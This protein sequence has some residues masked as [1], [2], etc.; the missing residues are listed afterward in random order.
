M[1][2]NQIAY[3]NMLTN[4]AA[5]QENARSNI[6]KETET[7]RSNV[8]KEIE[9]NRSNLEDERQ[10]RVSLWWK[11]VDSITGGLKDLGSTF[12]SITGGA[13]D[14][15]NLGTDGI[16]NIVKAAGS[17]FKSG[18]TNSASTWVSKIF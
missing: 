4:R 6:A 8:A 16:A 13:R 17:A 1:T 12:K 15:V 7:N 3:Q 2:A 14:I 18:N 5:Q 9:T 10:G 11:G